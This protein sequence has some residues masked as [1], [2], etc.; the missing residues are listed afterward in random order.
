MPPAAYAKL[1]TADEDEGDTAGVL[2]PGWRD[3]SPE[4]GASCFQLLSFGWINPLFAKAQGGK[5]EPEDLPAAAEREKSDALLRSFKREW[6]A[7]DAAQMAPRRLGWTLIKLIRK[8]W[9]KSISLKVTADMLK[10]LTPMAMGELIGWLGEPE[11]PPPGWCPALIPPQQ[12]G[13]YY[14][15]VMVLAQ[16]SATLCYAHSWLVLSAQHFWLGCEI[17]A[18]LVR[19]GTRATGWACGCAPW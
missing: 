6:E 13:Y 11:R 18:M 16:L 17:S 19:T 1:S 3:R 10:L 9:A 15:A 5:L 7:Q 8:V 4:S 14:V 2:P 12:R